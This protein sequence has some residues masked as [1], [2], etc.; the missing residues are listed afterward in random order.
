MGEMLINDE[1]VKNMVE[2]ICAV[3]QGTVLAH[4]CSN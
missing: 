3:F 1:Q 2:G 4:A